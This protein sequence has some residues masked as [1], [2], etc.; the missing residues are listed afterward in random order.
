MSIEYRLYNRKSLLD[1]TQSKVYAEAEHVAISKHRASS[2]YHNPRCQDEDI[3][4]IMAW[5]GSRLAGYV[6]VLPDDLFASDGNRIHVGWLSCL[7]VDSARRG[8]GIGMQMLV[9]ILAAW[10]Q[11]I[12]LTEFTPAAGSLYEKSGMFRYLPPLEGYRFYYRS[13]LNRI[14]TPKSA[15]L[16][17]CAPVF[18]LIDFCLNA[19][20]DLRFHGHRNRKLMENSDI[21]REDPITIH[22]AFRRTN[23]ELDWAGKH[24]W[25]IPVD[26]N[27][28][29]RNR[30]FF[31][32]VDKDFIQVIHTDADHSNS[33]FLATIRDGHFKVAYFQHFD[34]TFAASVIDHYVSDGTIDYV[35]IFDPSIHE[36]MRHARY[37]P[38]LWKKIK[39]KWMTTSTLYA[40]LTDGAQSDIAPGDGD[41][42]FT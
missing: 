1:Y 15:F 16:K 13:C 26:D 18:R 24:P 36:G 11:K 30:Y 4:M 9:Q 37:R 5:D 7:W 41:S 28:H 42:I 29:Y 33:L 21:L 2:Q 20:L 19:F 38:L 23:I 27:N 35:T 34:I 17:R 12:I 22:S 40:Y 39:R 8:H 14:L 10:K 32:A 31:S 25:L 6:G 3:I